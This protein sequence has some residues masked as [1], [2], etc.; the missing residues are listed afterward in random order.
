M[1]SLVSKRSLDDFWRNTIMPF[2][3]YRLGSVTDALNMKVWELKETLTAANDSEWQKAFKALN[4]LPT[5]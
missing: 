5:K 3:L 1:D 4:G 2:V